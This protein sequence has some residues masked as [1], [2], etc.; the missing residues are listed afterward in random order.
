MIKYSVVVPAYN[1]E[2]TVGRCLEALAAQSIPQEDYE[3]L[4]ID[5]GSTDGTARVVESFSNKL[6]LRFEGQPNSGPAAARNR[7]A[8]AAEGEIILFT[9]SDC[10]PT[11][12]WIE[13]M[14]RPF[15]DPDVAGAK[16]AYRTEQ[17]ELTAR[18]A[19]IEF[20]ERF[21]ILR[22]LD[23]I[24]MVDTYSA[25][26]RAEVFHGANGFD[27][28]F[29]VANNED[30]DLSYRL[31]KAGH[32]LVFN[33]SAVVYHLN[34]PNSLWRYARLKFWRG[35]WRMLVY[36]RFP[37][38]MLQDT[39]TP[40]TLKLQVLTLL[41]TAGLL[42]LAVLAA[43]LTPL[44]AY[45]FLPAGLMLAA[46]LVFALPFSLFAFRREPTVGV[47]SPVLLAVRGLSI[48]SGVACYYL[49]RLLPGRGDPS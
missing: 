6:T 35:Y 47:L 18:F 8:R 30:T 26:Y 16:G 21:E 48:G 24:D 37:N 42:L 14:V 49:G 15:E 44:S 36:R 28:S 20:E 40:K 29:P 17:K 11:Q 43:L 45:S 34:H 19:Q 38:M 10:V 22:K 12:N 3:V 2:R 7:G 4:V 39:Y 31:V 23:S 25:A 41:G 1:A 33:E 46:F 13:E 5:D 32:R 27:E 9:D